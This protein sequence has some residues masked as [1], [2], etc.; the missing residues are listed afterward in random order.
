MVVSKFQMLLWKRTYYRSAQVV[1]KN[2]FG[3]KEW[4]G[5]VLQEGLF[6]QESNNTFAV[7]YQFAQWFFGCFLLVRSLQEGLSISSLLFIFQNGS[8]HLG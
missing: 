6:Q 8:F 5:H 4:K 2:G 3:F 1:N 7:I